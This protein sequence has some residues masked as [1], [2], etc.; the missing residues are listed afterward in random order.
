MTNKTAAKHVTPC[1]TADVTQGH[2]FL[3]GPTDR[4]PVCDLLLVN[5]LTSYLTSFPSY[6]GVLVQIIAFH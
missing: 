2:R 1:L 5:C 4:K 3:V 6:R